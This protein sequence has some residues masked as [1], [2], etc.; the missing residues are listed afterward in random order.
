MMGQ[1]HQRQL[2][3]NAEIVYCN[4][5]KK[6]NNCF[7]SIYLSKTQFYLYFKTQRFG[8]WILSLFSGKTYSVGPNRQS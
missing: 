8:D 2:S 5:S 3:Q 1:Q 4:R 7:K 6:K